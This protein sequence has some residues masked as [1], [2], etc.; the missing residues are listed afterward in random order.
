MD[1]KQTARFL[2]QFEA[3]KKNVAEWPDWMRNAAK[4]AAAS[5][6]ENQMGKNAVKG[7]AEERQSKK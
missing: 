7:A 4:V 6:P 1:D 2:A 3:S 5:F